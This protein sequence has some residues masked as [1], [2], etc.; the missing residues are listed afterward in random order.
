MILSRNSRKSFSLIEMLVVIAIIGALMMI[1][2]PVI[3]DIKERGRM[4]RCKSNLRELH[5]A[6]ITYA[7]N[8]R[9]VLPYSCSGEYATETESGKTWEYKQGA[10]GWVDW[11]KYQPHTENN[12]STWKPGVTW[13]WGTNALISIQNGSLFQYAGS[14]GKIYVC[15]TFNQRSTAGTVAPN[16]NKLI[17]P[18]EARWSET[19]GQK[20]GTSAVYRCY[21]MNTLVSGARFEDIQGSRTVLFVE[22]AFTNYF[23]DR[24]GNNIKIACQGL[25]SWEWAWKSESPVN[26]YWNWAWDG[27]FLGTNY[28]CG[29]AYNYPYEAIGF[30]HN[31]RG[32]FI[33]VDGHTD[34][35]NYNL[36]LDLFKMTN[37]WLEQI[38]RG[39]L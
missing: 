24:K 5:I 28:N 11:V 14:N 1:L 30:W 36:P 4:I 32:N 27:G 22:K 10:T 39:N 13:W 21:A 9:A 12:S 23:R 18:G 16:G 3:G 35:I 2:M 19:G 33:F 26:E 37:S 31:G 34:T 20:G 25:N 6:T 8:N 15:P 17:Y 7:V 29:W 38:V